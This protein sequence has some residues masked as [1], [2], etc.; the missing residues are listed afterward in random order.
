MGF[1]AKKKND[2]ATKRIINF[3]E[4][5]SGLHKLA[6][7]ETG[8]QSFFFHGSIVFRNMQEKLRAN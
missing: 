4:I 1:E 3:D 5:L 2:G 6:L 7:L 8:I